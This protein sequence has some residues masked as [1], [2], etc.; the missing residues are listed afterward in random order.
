[1]AMTQAQIDYVKATLAGAGGGAR[2]KAVS[3][4]RGAVYFFSDIQGN[5]TGKGRYSIVAWDDANDLLILEARNKQ[6]P[7]GFTARI[8]IPYNTIAEIIYT[9]ANVGT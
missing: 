9:T 4:D 5:F 3:T 6:R 1:M 7:D 8:A 2:I